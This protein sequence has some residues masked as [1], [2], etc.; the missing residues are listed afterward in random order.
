MNMNF[1]VYEENFYATKLEIE[2]AGYEAIPAWCGDKRG[3]VAVKKDWGDLGLP[4]DVPVGTR[5]N[6]HADIVSER[7]Q[8][9]MEFGNCFNTGKRHSYFWEAVTLK[10]TEERIPNMPFTVWTMIA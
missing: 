3:Y 1:V 8:E 6:Y 4:Y 10:S 5:V 2:A 7:Y 9:G